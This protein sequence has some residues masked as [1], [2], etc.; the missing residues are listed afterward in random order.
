MVAH[1]RVLQVTLFNLLL[2]SYKWWVQRSFLFSFIELDNS[3]SAGATHVDG[4]QL[5][6][7]VNAFFVFNYL[8]ATRLIP[9]E[10]GGN[11]ENDL[12]RER[13]KRT[14]KQKRLFVGSF[15]SV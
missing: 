9:H 1:L 5:V 13:N 2:E 14:N 8:I 11:Q 12:K 10:T 7:M 4:D 15:M 6:L 3:L